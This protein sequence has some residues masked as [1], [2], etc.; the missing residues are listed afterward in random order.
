VS[1]MDTVPM[2]LTRT[3]P[4]PPLSTPALCFSLPNSHKA[5]TDPCLQLSAVSHCRLGCWDG[6]LPPDSQGETGKNSTRK[7]VRWV[8]R[9]HSCPANTEWSSLGDPRCVGGH[10][11]DHALSPSLG[12]LG[13]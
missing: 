4:G 13:F 8:P 2:D 5:L 7:D 6:P 9:L 12:I 3:S 11:P 10:I 1:T